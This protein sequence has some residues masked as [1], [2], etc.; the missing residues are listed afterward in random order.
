MV[1]AL[2]FTFRNRTVFYREH[3]SVMYSP[4]AHAIS[5]ALV[6]LIYCIGLATFNLAVFYW[7][8]GLSSTTDAW[9]FYWIGLSVMLATVSYFSHMLAYAT[10]S[11]QIGI[12]ALS[13]WTTFFFVASGF[14]IDGKTMAKGW[15]WMYWISPFHYM[16]EITLMAQ[17]NDQTRLVVDALTKKTIPINQV[18]VQFFNG[19]FSYDNIGRDF[20]ILV[21]IIVFLQLVIMRCM[22]KVNHTSR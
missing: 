21:A 22:A 15:V 7:L 2:T 17:Y 5:I 4:L 12:L 13:S 1:M 11:L 3:L 6:E 16:L 19:A 20:G 10:P 18:V 14:L 9:F 8:N